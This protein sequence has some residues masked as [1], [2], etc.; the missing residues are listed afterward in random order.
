MM[1]KLGKISIF[2]II[3]DS[4]LTGAPRHL[5]TLL[6]GINSHRFNVTVIAPPGSLIEQLK[7][8]KIPFFQVPMRGR[9][10]MAAISAVTKLLKKYDPDIIHTHGQRAGLIGRMASKGMPFKRVHTEHTYTH[11]F[12]LAN[13][14]LHW[15]HLRVMRMLDGGTDKVIAVSNAVRKFL[16][17][18]KISKP[19]KIVTI[20]NGIT[21]LARK[22]TQDEIQAFKDKFNITSDDIVIGTVGSFNTAKDTA[23]LVKAVARMVKKW[24]K[25]KL[26]LVGKGPLKFKL[27]KLIKSSGL[28]DRVVFTGSMGNVLPALKT[29]R[30]FVLPSL[31]EA[32]G[33]T[34]L[35]AMKAEIPVVATRVGG[36]PEI[37]T[38][39]HN[40]LL[41]EPKDSKKL[42]GVLMKLL[43]DRKLQTKLAK[44]GA[45]TLSKFSADRMI[46]HTEEIYTSLF[47]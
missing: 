21:P 17:D 40:G 37:I 38:Q 2:E 18:S 6:S 36:I 31:S 3:A 41:V 12:K 47:K 45:N 7:K 27:E 39:N 33:I 13:P 23:T 42:A 22:I 28:E 24:P 25:V 32:F 16:I 4:S 19:E 8:R 5:L 26:V 43:N 10:D 44:N 15:T 35:E 46:D 30:I 14:L 11:E 9:A 29:F 20:Y 1:R 34:I